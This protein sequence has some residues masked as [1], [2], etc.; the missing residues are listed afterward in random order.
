M[1]RIRGPLRWVGVAIA[2]LIAVV[3]IL[4]AVI[5]LLPGAD[6][7]GNDEEVAQ[8]LAARRAG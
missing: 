6:L 4:G 1:T 3:V 8:V 2:A 5:A 7:S